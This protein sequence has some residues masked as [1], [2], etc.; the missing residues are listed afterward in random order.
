M[1]SDE[2]TDGLKKLAAEV[3][4]ERELSQMA[5][6]VVPLENPWV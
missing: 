2:E 3:E 4:D 6:T 5:V 1:F